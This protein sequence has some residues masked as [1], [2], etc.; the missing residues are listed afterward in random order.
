MPSVPVTIPAPTL[1]ITASPALS[2]FYTGLQ[3]NLTCL[4]Q[5]VAPM[6]YGVRVS[7][8]WTKS[9]SLL[10]SDSRVRV[11]EEA[12]EVSPL[13]YSTSLVFSGLDKARGDDEN[14]TCTVTISS[15]TE[16]VGR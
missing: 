14:Y 1:T 12:V 6:G 10:T 15:V 2:Q 7:A 5:L 16:I 8:H 9:G 11:G 13:V 4:I 3:L